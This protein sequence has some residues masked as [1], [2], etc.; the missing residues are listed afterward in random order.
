MRSIPYVGLPSTGLEG[1]ARENTYGCAPKHTREGS[2][3]AVLETPGGLG[4]DLGSGP[5]P[6]GE[7]PSPLAIQDGRMYSTP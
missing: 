4:W 2:L 3:K 6:E 5:G 7:T 1:T